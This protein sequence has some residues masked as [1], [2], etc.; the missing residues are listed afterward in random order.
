VLKRSIS[1]GKLTTLVQ[2][3]IEAFEDEIGNRQEDAV[4]THQNEEL[5]SRYNDEDYAALI[6]GT[7]QET[8]TLQA[9]RGTR[10]GPT[11]EERRMVAKLFQVLKASE[12]PTTAQ[13]EVEEHAG[14]I[15]WLQKAGSTP[16]PPL[17]G[18]AEEEEEEEEHKQAKVRLPLLHS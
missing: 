13:K 10:V 18:L 15:N 16:L 3:E 9:S 6:L 14:F 2:A 8:T 4:V 12:E 11:P 1:T 5:P 7:T 17:S